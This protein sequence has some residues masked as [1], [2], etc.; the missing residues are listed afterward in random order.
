MALNFTPALALGLFAG[1]IVDRHDRRHVMIAADL[2]RAAAVGAIPLLAATGR[3]GVVGLGVAIFALAL[4]TTVFNPAIK[5]F[6]PE[7]TPARHLTAA[8]S[9]FQVADYAALVV[10]PLL[11]ALL[12]P[13]F[14]AMNLLLVDAATF[15][16]SAGCISLVPPRAPRELGRAPTRELAAEV[17]AGLRAVLADPLL[18]LL[19]ALAVLDNGLTMGLL[20][21]AA[22]LYVRDALALGT[23]AYLRAQTFFFLGMTVASA[24]CWVFGRRWPKGPTIIAGL[25]LD[26]LTLVPVAFCRTLG[27]LE[28]VMFVHACAIPLI[29]IPR[30]VLIQQRVPGALHGRTFALLN[31]TVFGMMAISS[32]VTGLLAEH[33]AVA[34]LFIALGMAGLL[35]GLLGLASRALRS[36][37]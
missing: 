25:V 1:A 12:V 32:G 8:A 20:H 35:P 37:R 13:R 9:L 14:G 16:F 6:I 36:E 2:V 3:L 4:G 21:V 26:G 7:L 24:A 33:V 29:I 17:V 27:Q 18:R 30:T 11:A 28:A 34:T 5:A 19:L 31:V 23:D 22:P 15:V 10:G